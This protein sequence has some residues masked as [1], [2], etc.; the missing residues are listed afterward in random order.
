YILMNDYPYSSGHLMVASNRH[1]G[2]LAELSKEERSEMMELCV[3]AQTILS[4]VMNPD[5]FNIGFNIGTAAGAGVAEHLHMHVVPRW[6]GDNNFMAV[7]ADTRVVPE[8]LEKTSKI[9]I[10][11]YQKLFGEQK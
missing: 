6:N 7:L 9:L 2:N 5:G 4:E 11:I 8:A 1:C 10:D 3:Q